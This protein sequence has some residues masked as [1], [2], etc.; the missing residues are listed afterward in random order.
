V[1]QGLYTQAIDRWKNYQDQTK[2]VVP[3]LEPWA[4][5]FGYSTEL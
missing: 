3:L 2:E 5:K 4:K 1:T